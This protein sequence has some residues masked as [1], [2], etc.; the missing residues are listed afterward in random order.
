VTEV[1]HR[2]M[3]ERRKGTHTQVETQMTYTH[4]KH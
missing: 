2:T 3:Q 4:N 1:F